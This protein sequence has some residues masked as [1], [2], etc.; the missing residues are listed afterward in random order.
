[1]RI[2]SF[3]PSATEIVYTLGLGDQLFGVTRSCDYP[4]EALSKPIVVRS[5][6]DEEGL[7]SADID[8]IVKEHARNG[9]SV[10]HIDMEALRAAEPDLILTQQ[11]CDVCAVGY[12]DVLAQVKDLPKKPRVVSLNPTS[13]GDV[14]EDM[15]TVGNETGTQARAEAA[16]SAL[17]QRIEAVRQQAAKATMRPRVFCLEWM[18]PLFVSGHWLPEMVEIAGGIDGVGNDR[19][20]ST[21]ITWETVRNYQPEVV[22]LMPC[23]ADVPKTLSELHYVRALP[24]WDELPA[25]HQGRIYAVNAGA[26][27][28]RSGPRLVDGLELLAQIIQPELFPWTAPQ[29]IALRVA[30][31]ELAQRASV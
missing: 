1:M 20:P 30:G 12:E 15:L 10:Y 31:P 13:L 3:L 2:C 16:V 5:I 26:Y 29:D 21:Q 23:G 28:S 11:L 24:G 7:T 18:D 9:Q 22:I 8:R 25:V 14:L 6:L 17:R 19:T 4:A 27:F